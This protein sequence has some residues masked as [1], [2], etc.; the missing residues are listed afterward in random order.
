MK[1][2]VLLLT[3]A[4]LTGVFATMLS[5]PAI[6]RTDDPTPATIA[7]SV[8]KLEG[9]HRAV[10][11]H[12]DDPAPRDWSE[13]LRITPDL[14]IASVER[15][16]G[17][18]HLVTAEPF[19][20]DRHYHVILPDG[21]KRFLMPDGILDSLYS[22]KPMG[23]QREG[24]RQA[25]RV[26][27]PRAQWVRLVLY[28][29]LTSPAAAELDM[30]RD[31]DGVWELINEENWTGRYYGY[32]VHG[33]SGN[34]EN[35]D[36]SVVIADPYSR[37]VASRN[38]YLHPGRTHI[39]PEIPYDWEGVTQ[40]VIHPRDLVVYEMHV[41][42]LTAHPSAG[43]DP[44]LRGS[45]AGLVSEDQ[46]GGLPWIRDLGVNA[47]QLLPVHDF[48]NYEIP[49][50]DSSG[51]F[52]NTWNPYE[53]NH[54]GY[55]TSYFFA[56]ETYY[57]V[58]GS[59]ARG[60]ISG[61]DTGVITEFKDMVKGFHR[62]GK[63]VILDVVYNHVSQYDLNP[64]K[65]LDKFYYFRLNDDCTYRS[66]S[67]CGN[68]FKTERPMARRMIIESVRFWM[69]EYRIDGFRF[70]LAALID[71]ETRK[72]IR[73]A[74]MA[75][76]P[77]VFL[78][79][80]P[81]GGGYDPHGFSDVGWMAWND[82]IRNGFKGYNPATD[83]GFIFGGFHGEDTRADMENYMMGSLRERGGQ[84]VSID[85]SVNYLAAH[86]NHT[87][88]DYI[89]IALGDVAE[90]AVIEDLEANARLSETQLRLNKLA[91][92]GLLT[93]QGAIMIH[94][95][96]EYARSKVIAPTEAPD[97]AVGRIDHN[98]YEKDNATNYLNFDHAELNRGLID[99]YRGLIALRAAHPA[100]RRA[101]PEQFTFV[102]TKDDH[103]M[104]F[105]IVHESGTY[106]VVL[107]GNRKS[108]G[109]VPLGEGAWRV[110]ADGE[111]VYPADG[112]E[113][114]GRSLSVPPSTGMV[115]IK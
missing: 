107:N 87:L 103:L 93:S 71:V 92:L 50:R 45:Y 49:F 37:L 36:S 86:D 22:D 100:L 21:D 75:I 112:P 23:F 47:V 25:F 85:H 31:P 72:Q 56:P 73:A 65:Y 35:F 89:R 84:F 63:A 12:G 104:A 82:R 8:A 13:A 46:R 79:A 80:E 28:N 55:M 57:A 9:P 88:G 98:S 20:L 51:V 2:T 66:D 102:E 106:L 109:M 15:R 74:A 17:E 67:G 7:V 43:L 41:R 27:A 44:E 58:G 91:A 53:R 108:S 113:M 62:N 38:T 33:P 54:W 52:F 32:R 18:T 64:F 76:N 5:R 99:Y 26:F 11:Y 114:H 30:L 24:S 90:D 61:A 42:D 105:T 16:P 95:G 111:G 34:G 83:R 115:L 70:D 1:P 97:S 4:I 59:M 77:N 39:L 3:T 10:L 96:Q 101:E 14:A 60:E 68:D 29:D 19:A 6:A 81:W 110:L 78:I 69:T 40:P 48:G 94:E